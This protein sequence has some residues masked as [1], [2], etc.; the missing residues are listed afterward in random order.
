MVAWEKDGF[1][2]LRNRTQDAIYSF[3]VDTFE[4]YEVGRDMDGHVFGG[5]TTDGDLAVVDIADVDKI[6]GEWDPSLY[7][8]TVD[9]STRNSH[10]N[11]IMISLGRCHGDYAAFVSWIDSYVTMGCQFR[12][13]IP[14]SMTDVTSSDWMWWARFG[15]DRQGNLRSSCVLRRGSEWGNWWH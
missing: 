13:G 10:I 3:R 1:R 2:F 6:A 11:D 8:F 14:L 9:L 15:S 5:V 4:L 12:G 7:R